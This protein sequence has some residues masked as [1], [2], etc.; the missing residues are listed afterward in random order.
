MKAR[1]LIENPKDIE[2]TI[3]LTMTMREWEEL[4]GQLITAWPSSRLS[5]T[6]TDLLCQ[7]RKVFY[8]HE[9]EAPAQSEKE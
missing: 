7:A 2:G 6:I 1:L 8:A 4:Q 9:P 5:Q 3:K